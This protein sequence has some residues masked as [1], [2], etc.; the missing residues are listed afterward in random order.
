MSWLKVYFKNVYIHTCPA[1]K[2]LRDS[3]E[4][5]SMEYVKVDFETIISNP[6][7]NFLIGF[8]LHPSK[9]HR[10]AILFLISRIAPFRE[11]QVAVC[12]FVPNT[13]KQHVCGF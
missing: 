12:S 8:V 5:S 7:F 11:N 13:P 2:E 6:Q 3:V 9:T 10:D 4:M 1:C